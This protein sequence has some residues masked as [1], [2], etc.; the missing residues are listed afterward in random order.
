MNVVTQY[1]SVPD[2]A[3]MSITDHNRNDDDRGRK[4]Q[5]VA[6]WRCDVRPKRVQSSNSQHAVVSLLLCCAGGCVFTPVS[7]EHAASASRR[8]LR[9]CASRSRSLWQCVGV[10]EG[11]PT[12]E[13]MEHSPPGS[14]DTSKLT[15]ITEK[16]PSVWTLHRRFP[17]GSLG[18]T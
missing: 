8:L 12:R 6:N 5:R 17:V 3:G 16:R 7:A 9:A 2:V 14:F 15:V 13:G 1:R 18:I 10:D 4:R 11:A